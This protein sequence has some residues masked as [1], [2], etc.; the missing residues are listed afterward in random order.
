[1]RVK[2]RAAIATVLVLVLLSFNSSNAAGP[3]SPSCGTY[4]VAKNE[5]I[6]G[7]K[8]A[9]GTYQI[10]AMGISCNKVLGS[11]GLFAQFLKLKDSA[12]LPKPWRYL[13]KAIGAPK[14][15]AGPGVGFRVQRV[16]TPTPTPTPTLTVQ[17]GGSDGN[18]LVLSTP[19]YLPNPPK[20][21][22]D[23]YRCFLLDPN[24]RKQIFLQSVSIEPE[25]LKVS[26]HGILYKVAAEDI[27]ASKAIDQQTV[28]P[29]WPCFGDTGIPGATA[30]SAASSSSW[31][32]FWAPGGDFRAYPAGTGME[33]A[34]GDQFILQSH[35]HL[36]DG[37]S[38]TQNMSATKVSL[39]LA[40]GT[41]DALK[42]L[43]IAAPIEIECSPKESG[44]LC[45]RSAALIDLASRTSDKAALQQTG[46]L[47][48]CGKDTRNP[49][50]S[51]IADCTT[52]VRSP[53]KIYGVTGHMHQLGRSIN[54]KYT[55]SSTKKS[56]IIMNRPLWDFDN[57]TTDWLPNPIVAMP[58]D[59]LKV[60]CSFDVGLRA[61]LPEF[62]NLTPNYIVW[63][64]GTRDEM[65]LAIINYTN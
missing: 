57:Q 45:N 2:G 20:N 48:L 61:L 36:I 51:A 39:T 23:E 50:P 10:H 47:F 60:T 62:K 18:N 55:E 27:S 41:V 5:I 63:G 8:F 43:L 28:E 44:P 6:A 65:C 54:V 56:S 9:K 52:T 26:H 14:F 46:L 31:I 13:A 64:E 21:G 17:P 7:Q 29:G 4:T 15:S 25:N 19:L 34:A 3:Q 42:T 12:P 1:M 24:I 49:K 11:K 35:F 30:F 37:N 32:A 53:I 22:R 40:T 59:T 33:I 16:L 58:G 38:P